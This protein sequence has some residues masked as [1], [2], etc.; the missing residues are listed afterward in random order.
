MPCFLFENTS[1]TFTTTLGSKLCTFQNSN[2][3]WPNLAKPSS[4]L[5]F[6]LFPLQTRPR[7]TLAGHLSLPLSYSPCPMRLDTK[8]GGSPRQS[9]QDLTLPSF[10]L[11]PS[12]TPNQ[13]RAA[14]QESTRTPPASH[15]PPLPHPS[16]LSKLE[17]TQRMLVLTRAQKASQPL[18]PHH[19]SPLAAVVDTQWLAATHTARWPSSSPRSVPSHACSGRR[20][21]HSRSEACMHLFPAHCTSP[22]TT[23]KP[24]QRAT[25]AQHARPPDPPGRDTKTV[26]ID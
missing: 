10:S 14:T 24:Q 1:E 9:C 3:I 7:H 8:G 13:H 20:E 19:P 5:F 21:R 4:F 15:S 17:A 16:P 18:L 12:P 6:P 22:C 2:E 25:L 23:S 26:H 11:Q